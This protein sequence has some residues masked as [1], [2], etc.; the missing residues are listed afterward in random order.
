V[1]IVVNLLIPRDSNGL[2]QGCRCW[3]V[4]RNTGKGNMA[5]SP[6][7]EDMVQAVKTLESA[8]GE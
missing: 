1:G 7:V 6:A 2:Y 8:E 5:I 4:E 3:D